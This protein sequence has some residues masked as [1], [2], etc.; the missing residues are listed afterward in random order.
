MTS[1]VRIALIDP[2]G[3][4]SSNIK[5][6]LDTAYKLDWDQIGLWDGKTIS[7]KNYE[8]GFDSLAKGEADLFAFSEGLGNIFSGGGIR[9]EFGKLLRSL[10]KRDEV[11]DI[12]ISES[13][14]SPSRYIYDMATFG[15]ENRGG[16]F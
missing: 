15:N 8:E 11:V 1:G 13:K 7:V 5:A 12:P 3:P 16:R 9:M 2:D 10:Q 14:A 6:I 4:S